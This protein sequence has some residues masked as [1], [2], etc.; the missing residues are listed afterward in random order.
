[1]KDIFLKYHF[2]LCILGNIVSTITIYNDI[3]EMSIK[4][5][6][7]CNKVLISNDNP[8]HLV[9]PNSC[10]K[11]NKDDCYGEINKTCIIPKRFKKQII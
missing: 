1:M 5:L 6:S 2:S 10:L 7:M 3:F 8:Y 9:D 11:E 4:L